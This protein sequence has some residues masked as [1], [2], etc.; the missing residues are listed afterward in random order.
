MA[1][2][3]I[4]I[5]A[6]IHSDDILLVETPYISSFNISKNRGSASTFSASIKIKTEEF[7]AIGR[8][9]SISAGTKGNV[10]KLFTGHIKKAVINP[11]WDDPSYFNL[12]V[13][14]NPAPYILTIND[15]GL[16]LN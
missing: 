11:C 5:R 16:A 12:P 4:A 14:F 15:I 13:S 2:Q 6:Q 3:E 1:I 9:I 10:K 7:T 8:E